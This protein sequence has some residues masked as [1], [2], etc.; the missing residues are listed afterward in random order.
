M[1]ITI[2]II[3]ALTAIGLAFSAGYSFAWLEISKYLQ[4]LKKTHRQIDEPPT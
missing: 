3:F 2:K 4:K 1:I